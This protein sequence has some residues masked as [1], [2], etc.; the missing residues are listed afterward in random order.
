MSLLTIV[1]DALKHS[2]LAL[3]SVNTVVG[4]TTSHAPG[5]LQAAKEELD[6]LA[7]RANWQKLTREHTFTTIAA[8]V[9]TTASAF[10]TDFD[11]F[12]NE[13]I[14]NRDTD[15][16]LTA[17]DA[18]EWQRIQATVSVLVD[19]H[20]RVRGGTILITPTPT[21]GHTIAYEYIST[22]K[23]RSNAGADQV[24]WAA[25][26]DTTVFP[27]PIVT[28]GVVWRYR[29]GRGYPYSAEAEEYERRVAEAILRDGVKPRLY[30]D[31][32]SRL[33]RPFPPQM[34]ETLVF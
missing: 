28:L 18:M 10:P 2:S 33:R 22:Y 14:W 12:V 27:E 11:R 24:T 23:V 32:P 7:T 3:P 29:R 6:S 21:A 16:E 34:P 8:A 4:N 1:Q 25:D 17:I 30:T 31:A 5:M 13:S 9:Q 20:Y 26:S 15:R 19:P